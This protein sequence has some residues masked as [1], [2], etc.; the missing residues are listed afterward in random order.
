MNDKQLNEYIDCLLDVPKSERI[1]SRGEW[2][3]SFDSAMAM[4]EDRHPG[5]RAPAF[6]KVD[7]PPPCFSGKVPP[8][9]K[10]DL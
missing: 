4:W 7:S 1:A 2:A 5:T 6:K 9:Y 3:I 10:G 8:I